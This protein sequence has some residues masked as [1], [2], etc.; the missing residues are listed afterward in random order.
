[1]IFFS[2]VWAVGATVEEDCREGFHEFIIK[3]LACND[4]V[5]MFNIDTEEQFEPRAYKFKLNDPPNIF[6]IM[7]DSQKGLWI[8]WIQTIPAFTIPKNAQFH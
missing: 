4:V 5:E 2:V 7:Y 3:L 8:N 1:M 6:D